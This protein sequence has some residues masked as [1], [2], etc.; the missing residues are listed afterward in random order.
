MAFNYKMAV[1]DLDGTLAESKQT[2]TKDMARL[3]SRFAL[4]VPVVIIS[5]GSFAQF[6]KQFLPFWD[7]ISSKGAEIVLL[8]VSGSQL[9]EYDAVQKIWKKNDEVPFPQEIRTRVLKELEAMIA[10]GKYD[11]NPDPDGDYVEDLGTQITFSALGQNA[12]LARKKTWDPDHSKRQIMRLC[13]EAKIPE[14]VVSLGG[15]TSLNILP[16]GFTKAVGIARLLKKKGIRQ[17]DVVFVGDALFPGGNDYSV[18]EAGMATVS[19][20]GPE[21]TMKLIYDWLS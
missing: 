14:I 19:V 10:S 6:E 12:A 20:K 7:D 13:L 1:F 3:L 8:P 17:E 18:K 4:R 5:G 15:M 21:E 16:K 11:L 9:Y 2:L